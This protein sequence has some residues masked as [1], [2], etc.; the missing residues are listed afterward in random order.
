MELSQTA[1][2]V[3]SILDS[4]SLDDSE[5]NKI[6]F[7]IG[8]NHFLSKQNHGQRYDAAMTKTVIYLYLRSVNCYQAL[9]EYLNL[10][11][12]NKIKS[13]FGTLDAHFFIRK[14]I[15]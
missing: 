6:G 7:L 2:Y 8:Q 1:P 5:I 9:C 11:H 3:K 15:Y 13:Y 10:P 14:R 4:E 12:P